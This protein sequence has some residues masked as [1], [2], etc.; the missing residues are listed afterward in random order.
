M[1]DLESVIAPRIDDLLLS[2]M[3]NQS[4][5]Q[6]MMIAAVTA[7]REALSDAKRDLSFLKERIEERDTQ[8]IDLLVGGL[9]GPGREESITGLATRLEPVEIRPC[10][11]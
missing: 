1:N 7:A 2:A 4:R 6:R 5:E 10:V 9:S 8:L 11:P 3:E